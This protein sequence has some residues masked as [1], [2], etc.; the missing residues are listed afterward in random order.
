M[1]WAGGHQ[2]L[3]GTV[4]Y[5]TVSKKLYLEDVV[6]SVYGYS[7]SSGLDS[8]QAQDIECGGIWKREK[9]VCSRKHG[10]DGLNTT[11]Y[12]YSVAK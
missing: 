3:E 6:Q 1:A 9:Y 5:K 2:Q 4:L 7:E 8:E 11:G 12:Q 10:L